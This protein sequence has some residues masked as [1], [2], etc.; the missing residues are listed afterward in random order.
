[1][2]VAAKENAAVDKAIE[3]AQMEIPDA[4]LKTQVRQMMNDF[5]SRR[6]QSQGSFHGAVLPVHRPERQDDGRHEATGS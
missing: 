3:N 4:M 1:M 6:M 5:A 2:H